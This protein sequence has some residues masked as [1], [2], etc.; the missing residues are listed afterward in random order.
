MSST[1]FPEAL[2]RWL[3]EALMGEDQ[4]ERAHDR[5]Y[6]AAGVSKGTFYAILRGKGG[7]TQQTKISALAQVL[8]TKSPMI[9]RILRLPGDQFYKEPPTVEL[10]AGPAG[11][12]SPSA[13]EK[14]LKKVRKAFPKG[15]VGP[16]QQPARKRRGSSGG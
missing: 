15:Q 4:R 5:I 11:V 12:G 16:D 3:A 8:G 2:R 9:D 7:A 10:P 1:P 14:T 13:S 6:R